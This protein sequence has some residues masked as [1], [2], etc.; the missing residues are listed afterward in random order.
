[1]CN[2]ARG[3][4]RSGLCT[5]RPD[6]PCT[7]DASL[8]P[9]LLLAILEC[10]RDVPETMRAQAQK[11]RVRVLRAKKVEG[12]VSVPIP[13]AAG[14]LEELGAWLRATVQPGDSVRVEWID[15]AG[16]PLPLAGSG[17]SGSF[18]VP[19]PVGPAP[20]VNPAPAPLPTATVQRAP[21]T[22]FPSPPAQAADA[23]ERIGTDPT[24]DPRS[25]GATPDGPALLAAGGR[26]LAA[27]L[28][29]TQEI[30]QS[31][32]SLIDRM[33]A[34]LEASNGEHAALARVAMG[35]VGQVADRLGSATMAAHARVAES[36][37][38]V[39]GRAVES[40]ATLAKAAAENAGE[41]AS[42]TG[43]VYADARAA[44]AAQVEAETRAAQAEA[45]AGGVPDEDAPKP[46]GSPKETIEAVT[47][48]VKEGLGAIRSAG[49][50]AA[51]EAIV[52]TVADLA[53]D[54]PLP[55]EL[56]AALRGL[57]PEGQA[58][59]LAKLGAALAGAA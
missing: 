48:L 38:S 34:R 55:A 7:L 42:I 35:Q 23:L 40:N 5:P 16:A 41:L 21:E 32:L 24:G 37:G 8:D 59:A 52:A 13:V 18:A 46:A 29:S 57:T 54:K 3:A 50:D 11:I 58:K 12:T 44:T 4:V 10:A 51:R 9:S 20:L 1:M 19:I 2:G 25:S 27:A 17:R 45:R 15:G 33:A 6:F 53:G 39:A 56:V 30:N 43:T 22:P 47:G 28:R 49:K 31:Q 36:L 26:A 14:A